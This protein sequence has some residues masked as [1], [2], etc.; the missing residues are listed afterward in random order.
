VATDPDPESEHWLD[1]GPDPDLA[2]DW[3]PPRRWHWWYALAAVT[4]VAAVLLTRNQHTTRPLAARPSGSPPASASAVAPGSAGRLPGIHPPPPGLRSTDQAGSG[5]GTI[6]TT[7]EPTLANARSV[8]VTELGHRLLD[9]PAG[10]ELF[11]QGQGVVVRIELRRGRVTRTAV[12]EVGGA[13]PIFFVVGADRA[14]VHPMDQVTG[15]VVS[16]AKPAVRLPPPLDRAYSV[17]PGPDPRHLWAETKAGTTSALSLLTLDGRPAG[18]QVPI[19]QDA[20]VQASDRAGNVLMFG[21]GGM[22]DA[23]LDGLHRITG[24]TL[25]AAGPTRWLALECDE[26]YRCTS[27]VIDRAT[28]Q[29]RSLVTPLDAYQQNSGAISPDGRM[30][31]LLQPDGRGASLLELVDL[32][33]GVARLTG[34]TTGSDQTRGGRTL[35]WSPDSSWLFVTDGNGRLLALDRTG[36]VVELEVPEDPI[37]QIALRTSSP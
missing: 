3:R 30:A 22:Y 21:I 34:V 11:G 27:V 1:L 7:F 18:I 14:I 17:L 15:Y 32:T 20:T 5:L 23:R 2:G 19:P 6:P 35:V 9:V 37:D 8:T 24:G 13:S 28:G 36:R 29:R 31:A 25:L 16:D 12:P 4:V 33:T 26:R 10:W